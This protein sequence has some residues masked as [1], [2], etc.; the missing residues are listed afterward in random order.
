MNRSAPIIL[1]SLM[2]CSCAA[3]MTKEG[4]MVRQVAPEV[5]LDFLHH[6]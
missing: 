6:G 4:A 3:P 5:I 1:A 2:L